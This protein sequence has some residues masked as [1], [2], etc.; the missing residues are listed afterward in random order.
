MLWLPA[1]VVNCNISSINNM[2][3]VSHSISQ[4]FASVKERQHQLEIVSKCTRFLLPQCARETI[5]LLKI[6]PRTMMNCMLS[7]C[8]RLHEKAIEM[9]FAIVVQYM[10]H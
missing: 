1:N 3:V 7:D 6:P 5:S 2:P 9:D 8:S 10:Q 4:K